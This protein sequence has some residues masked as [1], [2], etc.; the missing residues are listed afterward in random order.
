MTT[1][2][3]KQIVVAPCAWCAEDTLQRVQACNPLHNRWINSPRK[4][5]PKSHVVIHWC[6]GCGEVVRVK[7]IQTQ[8]EGL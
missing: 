5:P 6:L 2:L 7:V 3:P 8:E 1:R 4:V